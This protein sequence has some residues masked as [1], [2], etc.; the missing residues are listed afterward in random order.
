MQ[1]L[2]FGDG[3]HDDT[4][5][6]QKLLDSGSCC[7]Y[8]PPP[9]KYYLISKPLVIHSNQE[10]RLD[11]Y[12]E[13]RLAPESDCTMIINDDYIHGNR[14]IAITGGIWNFANT[15]QYPNPWQLHALKTLPVRQCPENYSGT[16]MDFRN[17]RGFHINGITVK[18][19]TIFAVSMSKITEFTVDDVEFDFTTCNPVWANMD[20][21]HL[22][23]SCA[24][25]RITNLH[26]TCYDDLLALNSPEGQFPGPIT[27]IDI[28]G[29]YCEYC[30]S[31][32]RLLSYTEP[33]KRIS[34]K[35]IHGNFYRYMVGITHFLNDVP[36]PGI[37]D[38]IIIKDCF[39]GKALPPEEIKGLLV[40]MAPIL[41]EGF[42][43]IG[44]LYISNI[45]REEHTEA[46]PLIACN[47]DSDRPV[48]ADTRIRS[49]TIENCT[50][51][52]HLQEELEMFHNRGRIDNLTMRN[53]HLYSAP[54]AG[55]CRESNF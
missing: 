41:L 13:I 30:H 39:C 21:V 53:N 15:T 1:K 6:I 11:R 22:N 9:G 50:M 44:N 49:L 4:A 43:D 35:N 27:D 33:V 42:C 54:G 55:A 7:I 8:L 51:I 5:A 34:I 46:L 12:S 17:I 52:N 10:L 40:P 47:V 3:I 36:G 37:F 31:A 26:G 20:G 18:D 32:V 38:D 23:G 45:H 16:A 48:I 14:N 24:Y 25:G 2:L 28:D 19:P 29:I